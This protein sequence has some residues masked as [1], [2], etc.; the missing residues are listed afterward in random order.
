MIKILIVEDEDG[1]RRSLANA[2]SWSGLGC[3]LYGTASSGMEALELCVRNPPD[4]VISDIVMPGI[5]GLSFIKYVKEKYPEIQFI[6]LTGHRN[7]DYAK[8]AVNLGAACFMLKPVNF[9][10]LKQA[11]ISLVA[12]IT[13]RQEHRKLEIQ[14]EQVLSNILN[15]HYYTP[16]SI[17]PQVQNFLDRLEKYQLVVFTFDEDDEKK[18]VLRLEHLLLYCRHLMEARYSQLHLVKTDAEHLAFILPLDSRAHDLFGQRKELSILQ[19]QISSFFKQSV[20]IGVSSILQGASTL[21]EAYIQALRALGQRFFSGPLS[22]NFFLPEDFSKEMDISDYNLASM[23]VSQTV[24]MI[25]RSEGQFLEQLANDLFFQIFEPCSKN[26]EL[27]K[28]SF[29]IIAVLCIKKTVKE[30]VRQMAMFLEKYGNF[31]LAVKCSNFEALKDIYVNLVCDLRDYQTMKSSSHQTVI[32]KVIQYIQ[33][34]YQSNISLNEIAR[35][36]YL[37]PSYLSSIIT[38]E[39]GKSFVDTLNEVR[40]QKSI[41]LLKNPKN[42]ITDIAYSVGFKE[43]QYFSMVFKKITSLT[44]RDYREMHLTA[45][46]DPNG[47]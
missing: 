47:R 28:S 43:P 10:E 8:D 27:I 42:R 24:Q 19:E 33:E 38:R 40:I 21:H 6:I 11:I 35:N 13:E 44:P 22:I 5:D 45:Q 3:E 20:S 17:L 2:F 4:I 30:D 34:N 25:T 46:P 31:Q 23:A 16:A 1:I 14:Q 18:S 29:I 37:S 32:H 36:V 15:G 41:E 12:R 26:I 9:L 7:F 39:T